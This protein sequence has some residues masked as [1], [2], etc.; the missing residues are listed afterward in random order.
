ML[1]SKR[2]L[3]C[4]PKKKETLHFFIICANKTSFKLFTTIISFSERNEYWISTVQSMLY[5]LMIK[6]SAE[7]YE[8]EGTLEV[9]IDSD[10]YRQTD[11]AKIYLEDN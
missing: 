3:K 9:N 7:M 2:Y 5:Y 6:N 8:Y 11:G 4:A 1:H 10:T